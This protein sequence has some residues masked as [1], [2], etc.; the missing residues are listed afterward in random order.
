MSKKSNQRADVKNPNN[1]AY[2]ADMDNRAGLL[3]PRINEEH[4]LNIRQDA[5]PKA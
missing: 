2:K 4:P 3:N 1:G 5:I